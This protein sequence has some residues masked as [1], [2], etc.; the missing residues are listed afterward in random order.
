MVD[1]GCEGVELNVLLIVEEA[2]LVVQVERRELS[3]GLHGQEV[4]RAEL[5]AFKHA[6][7]C[8]FLVVLS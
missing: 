8:L 1:L 5:E 7:F 6:L 2:L 3:E 4:V